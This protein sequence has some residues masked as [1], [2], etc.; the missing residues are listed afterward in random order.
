MHKLL[1]IVPDICGIIMLLII[2]IITLDNKFSI[3]YFTKVSY[4]R[5]I[6]PIKKT[7]IILILHISLLPLKLP[8]NCWFASEY[9]QAPRLG[10][11]FFPLL[12]S[13]AF[14]CSKSGAEKTRRWGTNECLQV[15]AAT[16]IFATFLR[17][18]HLGWEATELQPSVDECKHKILNCKCEFS[19]Y[20]DSSRWEKAIKFYRCL[21]SGVTDSFL[22]LPMSHSMPYALLLNFLFFLRSKNLPYVWFE[23]NKQWLKFI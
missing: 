16:A 6:K 9:L 11:K 14:C 20:N 1:R 7:N 12:L 22:I 5:R 18:P 13:H 8:K 19:C 10:R 15:N 21:I 23:I 17:S 4:F 2:I 3:I